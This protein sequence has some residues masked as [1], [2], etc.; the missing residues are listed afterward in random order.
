LNKN[1]SPTQDAS[2]RSVQKE[3]KGTRSVQKEG[4]G[5]SADAKAASTATP[6]IAPKKGDLTLNS[7]DLRVGKI[8]E[9]KRHETADKLY[10]EMIDVGE[11]EPRAIASGLVP[12]YSLEQMQ[13]RQLI[14]VANLKARN[15]VGFKSFG[16]VLCAA[17]VDPDT[18][19]EKVEFIDPPAGSKVG[20]RVVIVTGEEIQPP[21]S[22]SQVEKQ[23]AFEVLAADLRVGE[24]GVAKWRGFPLE[25][26]GEGTCTAP[27]LKDAQIR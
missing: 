27:T 22:S 18:G 8:V 15:L 17:K 3:G 6:P 11:A 20:S 14:V 10:C 13:N 9:V 4:K 1:D 26:V 2:T 24:D 19:A 5:I 16:M 7:L 21:L 12:H 23:K 25:V